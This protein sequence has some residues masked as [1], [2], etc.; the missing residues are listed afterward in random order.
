[1]K[2]RNPSNQAISNVRT[3]RNA[4]VRPVTPAAGTVLPP[5]R[6]PDDDRADKPAIYRPTDRPNQMF[7]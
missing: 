1:M 5:N 3:A 4:P 6:E 2:A 7:N